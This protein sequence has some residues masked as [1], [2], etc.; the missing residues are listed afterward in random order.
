M[1]VVL[2]GSFTNTRIRYK[3]H[4]QKN[5]INE[6]MQTQEQ[7]LTNKLESRYNLNKYTILVQNRF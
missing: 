1:Q 2:K 7:I 3:L 5:R 6:L 4:Q